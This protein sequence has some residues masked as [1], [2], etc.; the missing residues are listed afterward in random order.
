MFLAEEGWQF[1]TSALGVRIH[2][3]PL[4]L[5]LEMYE[6]LAIYSNVMI[7]KRWMVAQSESPVESNGKHPS[8][9]RVFN[10]LVMQDV[11]TIHGME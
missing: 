7:Q 8:I 6:V 11:A 3:R 1:G 2:S 10:H 9:Y 5:A 4:H